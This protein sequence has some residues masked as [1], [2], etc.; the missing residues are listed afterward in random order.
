MIQRDFTEIIL[1]FA[2]VIL[3]GSF[4]PVAGFFLPQVTRTD[5]AVVIDCIKKLIIPF[6]SD[7]NIF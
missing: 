6:Y 1:F 7:S 5:D 3:L 4:N 2:T